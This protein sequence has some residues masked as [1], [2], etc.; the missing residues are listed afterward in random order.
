MSNCCTIA[1]LSQ[2]VVF[3][4]RFVKWMEVEDGTDNDTLSSCHSLFQCATYYVRARARVCV[5]HAQSVLRVL[6]SALVPTL[7][8]MSLAVL[9]FSVLTK[10]YVNIL[11]FSKMK[12]KGSLHI[13][14]GIFIEVM[15]ARF[16]QS[17]H[18]V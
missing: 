13:I 7:P 15:V 10:F 14:Y 16:I 2:Y 9:P 3:S 8:F 6:C 18:T 17:K 12:K 1:A 4:N 11:L 5:N